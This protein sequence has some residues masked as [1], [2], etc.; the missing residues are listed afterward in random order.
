MENTMKPTISMILR[1]HPVTFQKLT[2]LAIEKYEE[3]LHGLTPLYNEAEEKRL[4]KPNRQR[5]RGGGRKQE[6]SLEDKLIMLLMYYRLYTTHELLG[7]IFKLHNSN[8]SRHINQLQP[9]LGKVF[10]IPTQRITLLEVDLT[11]EQLIDLF[12]DATEQQIQ[13]PHR[14]QKL[15]YSGKKKKHTLKNQVVVNARGKILSVSKSHPGATHDKKL[16][17]KTHVYTTKKSKPIADLGYCG[18]TTLQLPFK[19]PKGKNLTEEQKQFNK[20]L[21]RRRIIIEHIIGKMKIFQ[22]LVQTFRNPLSKHSLIFKNV[23]GIHNLMFA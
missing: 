9:L 20:K 16:Y 18:V 11:E 4:Y 8:V 15:Y 7:F 2:G 5:V 19:K 14:K 22:I 12:I 23:A 6:L 10:R 1:K 13:R 17:T 21:S 3:L